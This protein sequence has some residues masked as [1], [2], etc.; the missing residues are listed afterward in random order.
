MR[1]KGEKTNAK[2]A[3]IISGSFN[4]LSAIIHIAIVIAFIILGVKCYNCDPIFYDVVNPMF[5]DLI[6]E[7]PSEI[8]TPLVLRVAFLFLIYFAF[9]F[10]IVFIL[11]L[12]V[13]IDCFS[14][15]R[16][17]PKEAYKCRSGIRSCGAF[18]LLGAVLFGGIGVLSK[19]LPDWLP[20][21]A[22]YSQFLQYGM[23][24]FVVIAAL[25]LLSAIVKFCAA[26]SLG[27]ERR[28]NRRA[29]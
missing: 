10:F 3:L 14:N 6:G 9:L 26:A 22:E 15:S 7:G 19:M 17:E 25:L 21:M 12:S 1:E 5:I 8:V 18:E 20:E 28:K 29:Q 24:A 4:T 27:R 2:T 16:K 11:T 23:I 13:A